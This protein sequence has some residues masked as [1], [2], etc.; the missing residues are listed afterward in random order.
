MVMQAGKVS[1]V[2]RNGAG[3]GPGA[4]K[5]LKKINA[6]VGKFQME[7]IFVHYNQYV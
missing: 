4:K 5:I 1:L 3:R 2:G 6:R 7:C